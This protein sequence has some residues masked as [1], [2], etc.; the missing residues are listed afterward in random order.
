MKAKLSGLLVKD[1]KRR[2]KSEDAGSSSSSSY[3]TS[4]STTFSNSFDGSRSYAGQYYITSS[5]AL[6]TYGP[7]AAFLSPSASGFINESFTDHVFGEKDVLPVDV[8]MRRMEKYKKRHPEEFIQSLE[9]MYKKAYPKKKK[10]G[11]FGLFGRPAR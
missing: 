9:Q 1:K 4:F 5:M 3:S 7:G 11:I 2:V 8:A 6:A 10:A